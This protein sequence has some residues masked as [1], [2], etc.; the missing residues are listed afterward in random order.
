MSFI[1]ERDPSRYRLKG[2]LPD[3]Q[4]YNAKAKVLSSGVKLRKLL[5]MGVFHFE[6]G[7]KAAKYAL[8]IIARKSESLGETTFY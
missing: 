8:Q 5:P 6:G 2:Y 4:Y 1:F 3:L 7:I